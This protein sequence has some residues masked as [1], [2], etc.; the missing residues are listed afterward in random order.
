MG[1]HRGC[2]RQTQKGLLALF[3]GR[4]ARRRAVGQRLAAAGVARAWPGRGHT[5][6]C[7]HW[8]NGHEAGFQW[9][10]W[11]CRRPVAAGSA[12][13]PS[14]SFRQQAQRQDEDSLLRWLEPLGMRAPHGARAVALA[15]IGRW[16]R[17][18]DAGRVCAADLTPDRRHRSER[19][20]EAEVVSQSC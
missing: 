9:P 17:A 1:L 16:P 15:G 4:G 7:G 13:R 20:R 12:E 2:D 14:V 18:V 5:H 8:R 11:S 6:L 3:R 10:S 19:N